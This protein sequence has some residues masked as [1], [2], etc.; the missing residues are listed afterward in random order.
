[1]AWRRSD[2][3]DAHRAAGCCW[4]SHRRHG[5]ALEGLQPVFAPAERL[6]SVEALPQQHGRN[7]I[8]R[9]LK[10][11]AIV[12]NSLLAVAVQFVAV[13]FPVPSGL[14]E[15]AGYSDLRLWRS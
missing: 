12:L 6:E 9:A 2:C 15:C 13:G 1:M 11:L 5:D 10:K 3:Y 14:G 8:V 4:N 7:R